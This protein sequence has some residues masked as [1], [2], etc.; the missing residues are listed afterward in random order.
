VFSEGRDSDFQYCL[1]EA[2][3]NLVNKFIPPLM[4]VNPLSFKVSRLALHKLKLDISNGEKMCV[5]AVGGVILK[6]F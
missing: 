2:F 3:S 6:Y 5:F 4:W 1:R